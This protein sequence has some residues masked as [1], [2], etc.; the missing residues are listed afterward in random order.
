M[1]RIKHYFIL[2]V[3]LLAGLPASLAALEIN[4][5]QIGFD[6][7][8][9]R[10]HWCPVKLNVATTI[11][12]FK[13]ELKCLIDNAVY[14]FPLDIPVNQTQSVFSPV[15]IHSANP[16]IKISVFDEQTQ[17]EIQ[18]ITGTILKEVPPD[19]FLIGI[20]KNLYHIFRT[21]CLRY[22]QAAQLSY[23]FAF[24]LDELPSDWRVLRWGPK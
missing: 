5:V 15:V 18:H 11:K 9:R 6:N 21:E 10:G 14:V 22:S 16:E 7:Y 17:K 23:F 2:L 3:L 4:S 8:Y 13:G 1:Y 20:E 12:P 24:D 19:G